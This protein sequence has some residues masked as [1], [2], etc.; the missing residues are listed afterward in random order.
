MSDS[1]PSY[2][3]F[4]P[5]FSLN[6]SSGLQTDQNSSES[7]TELLRVIDAFFTA[8]DQHLQLTASF[9]RQPVPS[10]D[11]S[12]SV[13]DDSCDDTDVRDDEDIVKSN[14]ALSP[15]SFLPAPPAPAAVA[16]DVFDFP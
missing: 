15:F 10:H 13:V 1:V 16:H 7:M 4:A 9:S 2:L 11:T 12:A 8:R 3:R 6:F 5:T 14:S